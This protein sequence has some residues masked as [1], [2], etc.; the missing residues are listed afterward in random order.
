[1]PVLRQGIPRGSIYKSRVS[2]GNKTFAP[3]VNSTLVLGK[4]KHD[5]YLTDDEGNKVE[6]YK[7]DPHALPQKNENSDTKIF[8]AQ[9]M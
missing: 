1:M 8:I 2:I 6:I 5:F 9:E 7:V 4:R 3:T